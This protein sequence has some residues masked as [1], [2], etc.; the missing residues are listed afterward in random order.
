MSKDFLR[1]AALCGVMT[2]AWAQP[3]LAQSV[4]S[5]T[6]AGS[7]SEG[8]QG[9][10]VEATGGQAG[11]AQAGEPTAEQGAVGS[12]SPTVH[13]G[14]A[15]GDP[16]ALMRSGA[17]RQSL[18]DAWWTGPLL[19]ASAATLPRGHVL[20]EPYFYEV[21]SRDF[22][23]YGSRSY[24]L[25]GLTDDVTVGAIPIVGHNR[26]RGGGSGSGVG[27][28]DVTLMAQYRLTQFRPGGWV[29]TISAV[30]QQSLPSGRHDRLGKRPG[31]GLGTGAY[32]T[33]I[34]LYSQTYFWMP[35][36]R[37]L[38]ARLNLARSF[39]NRARV[40]GVSVYGTGAGF[41]GH[42]RPGATFEVSAAV[43]YSLTR[44]WVLAL[45]IV[46]NR[47]S[48]TRVSGEDQADPANPRAVNYRSRPYR[49][50]AIAPAI[51]Y[52]WTG[53]LGVIFG[54]RVIPASSGRAASITPA[55]AI[56][57]FF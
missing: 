19:T 55:M 31:N 24:V 5:P 52:N 32:A 29:P 7:V 26:I 56:N 2:G 23:H 44:N 42:A 40:D 20:V 35:N 25:Y 18:S 45:D 1:C 9:S 37:I 38:R 39:A 11:G 15:G 48:P 4:A 53:N 14:E 54:A 34:A 46:H 30:V 49:G 47:Q 8:T 16:I 22:R 43:E 33:T 12:P 17:V 57:M 6:S 13:D 36:G 51:E 3:G 27:L 10:H 50:F 28:G 41:S 21:I